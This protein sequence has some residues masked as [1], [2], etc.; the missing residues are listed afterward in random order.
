MILRNILSQFFTVKW[1]KIRLI[2]KLFLVYL[3][4]G[5]DV[6]VFQSFI[7][8]IHDSKYSVTYLS[9]FIYKW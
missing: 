4:L 5:K 8:F 6:I 1:L 9:Y 7:L 2:F 3:S